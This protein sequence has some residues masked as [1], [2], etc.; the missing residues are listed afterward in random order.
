M[1][2]VLT[3]ASPTLLEN[4]RRYQE[5]F[6]V[7]TELRLQNNYTSRL[8][9]RKGTLLDNNSSKT[10][11][12]SAR[13]HDGAYYGFSSIP[14]FKNDDIRKVIRQATD[15]AGL[16][17]K[18]RGSSLNED[19]SPV[20]QGVYD[21]R[22]KREKWSSRRKIDFLEQLNTY[23]EK[24]MSALVNWDLSL[25]SLS[26][27]KALITSTGADT[28]SFIPR[29]N[30]SANFSIN[31]DN[32]MVD[33]YDVFG[34]FG[35]IEDLFENPEDYFPLLDKLYDDIRQKQNGI[36]TEAGY[37]DVVLDSELAGILAHEAIGHTV[38]A[39]M[40]ILSGGSI[41]ADYLNEQVASELVT[42]IDGPERGFDGKANLAI[43]VDDE[44]TLCQETVII[45]RGILKSYLHNKETA[46]RC[47]LP[48]TGNARAYAFSDEPLVRM[49]N[50][51][52]KPGDSKLKDMIGEIEDG[53]YFIKPKSGQ[54]DATSE[55]MFGVTQGYEIKNGQIGRALRDTTVSGIAFDMLKTITHVSNDMTWGCGGMCGKKQWIPVGMGGPAIKCKINVGGR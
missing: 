1:A 6:S 26:M 21:Y 29:A 7:Y 5:D 10:G 41:A 27:E 20:G 2:H 45:D 28:Y 24:N 38:E 53:Y 11:G 48:S 12:V 44:G 18:K 42:L 43:H 3:Q 47:G 54:A 33:L 22:S 8:V 14:S 31:S 9:M 36:Y 50:T 37:K 16:L 13:C 35:E 34:G 25:S 39:D 46:R 17:R 51:S 49:R 55:F 19:N 32:G 40:V 15:N 4:A 23:I 30:L 52:I